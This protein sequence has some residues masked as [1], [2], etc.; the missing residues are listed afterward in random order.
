[1]RRPRQGLPQ[2]SCLTIFCYKV[3]VLIPSVYCLYDDC[4]STNTT[5]SSGLCETEQEGCVLTSQVVGE[6]VTTVTTTGDCAATCRQQPGEGV[7]LTRCRV[8]IVPH[9]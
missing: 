5:S 2:V 8:I 3:M 6:L 1:M 9:S 7:A 4:S